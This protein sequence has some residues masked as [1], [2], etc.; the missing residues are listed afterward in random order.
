MMQKPFYQLLFCILLLWNCQS[1]Q[2]KNTSGHEADSME[3]IQTN[4]DSLCEE[5]IEQTSDFDSLVA[6]FPEWTK[7][8]IGRGVFDSR[9]E[10]FPYSRTIPRRIADIYFPLNEEERSAA[11][12]YDYYAGYRIDTNA[13]HIL[14]VK[15]DLDAHEMKVDG[16][17]Y[18]SYEVMI[19]SNEGKLVNKMELARFGD[20]WS[21][22]IRGTRQPLRFHL[23]KSVRT[24]FD[25]EFTPF[26]IHVDEIEVR[27]GTNGS[28]LADTL[29][30][31]ISYAEDKQDT[32]GMW[33]HQ[34]D[35][36]VEEPAYE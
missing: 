1:G 21:G 4:Q 26:P 18:C 8:T 2:E 30:S 28:L 12:H 13:L 35:R 7:D 3:T 22:T 34:W 20:F 32:D 31:Y 16:Y 27:L 25:G 36:S 23:E 15:R 24:D 10:E 5:A 9:L 11:S 19:F 17:P 14:F 29:R 33:I 6:I